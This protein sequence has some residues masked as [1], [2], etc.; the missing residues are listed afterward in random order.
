MALLFELRQ[1]TA[2]GFQAFWDRW[3]RKVAKVEAQKAW[4]QVVT[5]ED[6]EPIQRALDW[7]NPIFEAREP[8][9]RPHAATWIRGRRWE[10]EPPTKKTTPNRI[11]AN[12]RPIPT[13]QT[14][15]REAIARIQMLIDRGMSVEDAKQK[16]Y[17]ELGWIK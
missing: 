7:Q 9:Y 12:V 16:V 14:T 17:K 5:P 4:N 13:E 6:E 3:I 2:L 8:E 15:Q 1:K 10:D 11:T